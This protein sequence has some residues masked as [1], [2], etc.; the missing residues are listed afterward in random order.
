MPALR[1]SFDWLSPLLSA[2]S[3]RARGT[4]TV[5]APNVPITCRS[6]WP[7][8]CRRSATSGCRGHGPARSCGYCSRQAASG[9]RG[10]RGPLPR[11]APLP[12][13]S[14]QRADR[15]RR[16]LEACGPQRIIS[17]TNATGRRCRQRSHTNQHH[18]WPRR[19]RS[20]VGADGA[21]LMPLGGTAARACGE[22]GRAN[23]MLTC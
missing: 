4:D 15:R 23:Y 16:L 5:I 17:G 21:G 8:R 10:A 1:P 14:L 20:S 9:S 2:P 22:L 19:S 7:L 13:R 11:V 3:S 18:E 12:P 6:R